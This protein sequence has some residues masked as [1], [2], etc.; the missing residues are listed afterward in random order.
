MRTAIKVDRKKLTA[1]VAEAEKNGPLPNHDKL[2]RAAAEIYNN[3]G[4]TDKDISHSVVKARV[5]EWKIPIKTIAGKRGRQGPMSDEQKQ[6]MQE[7]RAAG[8]GRRSRAEKLKPFA[9]DFEDLRRVTPEA[10]MGDV[11]K[12]IGGS[13]MAGIRRKCMDCSDN[14][15]IDVK[16]CTVGGECPLFFFRP[17]AIPSS[18]VRVLI[19][20]REKQEAKEDAAKEAA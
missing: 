2:W 15:S 18:E 14:K 7:A 3:M 10:N 1:A 16:L 8:G 12:I 6:K 11:E 13:A 4:G 19:K 20:K 5:E 9:K 17:H